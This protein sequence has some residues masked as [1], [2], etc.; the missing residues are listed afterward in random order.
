M[1]I[2]ASFKYIYILNLMTLFIDISLKTIYM[3]IFNKFKKVD[4]FNHIDFNRI[5]HLDEIDHLYNFDQTSL[6]FW[7][8][9]LEAV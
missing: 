9:W 1:I 5:V 2:D 7:T 4:N 8:Y 6:S 3:I